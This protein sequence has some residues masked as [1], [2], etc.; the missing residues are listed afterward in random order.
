MIRRPPRSTRTDTLFPYTTLFRTALAPYDVT[1]TPACS[2]SFRQGSS[3]TRLATLLLACT[4]TPAFAQTPG[5]PAF[6]AEGVRA[7]VE[8]LADDLPQG[9]HSGSP[10]P[11]IDARSAHSESDAPGRRPTGDDT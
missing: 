5:T 1:V 7:T 8:F 3:M 2:T 4:A 10:G 9:R 11:E 6:P